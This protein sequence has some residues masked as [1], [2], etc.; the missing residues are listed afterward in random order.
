MAHGAFRTVIV[1]TW[2]PGSVL[3]V[4]VVLLASAVLDQPVLVAGTV[5]AG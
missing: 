3:T 2:R 5:R 4:A 1:E